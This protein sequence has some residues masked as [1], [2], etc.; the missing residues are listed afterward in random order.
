MTARNARPGPSGNPG[1]KT[2]PGRSTDRTEAAR[3]DG[4]GDDDK[5]SSEFPSSHEYPTNGYAGFLHQVDPD[6]LGEDWIADLREQW[7]AW[8]R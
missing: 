7:R 5:D 4:S 3:T 1:R 2:P 8:K 6:E